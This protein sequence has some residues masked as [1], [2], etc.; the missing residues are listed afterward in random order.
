MFLR[1]KFFA[2]GHH[3]IATIESNQTVGCFFFHPLLLRGG[4][5]SIDRGWL[6]THTH[7]THTETTRT[8]G[9]S[10]QKKKKRKHPIL[11]LR[12]HT[13]RPFT[14]VVEFEDNITHK[15]TQT[16]KQ[17]SS[18]SS[19]RSMAQGQQQETPFEVGPRYQPIKHIGEGAYGM[20]W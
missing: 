8:R 4:H 10:R 17:S 18:S 7:I 14:P 9:V 5:T 19:S 6:Q 2:S 11:S 12:R 13:V 20:V 1:R 16:T 15:N 3:A